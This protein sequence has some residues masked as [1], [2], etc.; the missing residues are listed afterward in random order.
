MKKYIIGVFILFIASSIFSQKPVF[1]EQKGDTI[2]FYLSCDGSLTEKDKATY[3]RI[4]F[5]DKEKLA[6]YG[7]II[8][9]YYPKGP[10]AL[11]ARYQN[12]LYDGNII[13][14]YKTGTIKETGIYKSNNRDS[15]WTFYFKNESVEKKIDY[16]HAQQRLIEYYNK[17]GKPVFL[18]GNGMYKGYSNKDYSS[19]EEYQIKGELKDGVMNGRWTINL[20]YSVSTE[21]FENGKFI[22]GHET[23]HNLI[24]EDASLINLSGFPYYEK[25]TLLDYSIACNK[26]GFYWPT[27]NKEIIE[28]S[29]LVEL[30]QKITEKINTNDFFYALLEFQLDNGIINSNSFK[31]ITNDKKKVDELKNFILS[32]DKWDTPK[33]KLSFTIYLPIFWENGLIYL[34]PKDIIKF[35]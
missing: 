4:G 1:F 2:I 9:Y 22:R 5:F 6:F 13:N 23:P 35:N 20:G 31:S 14:Y 11:K 10:I 18:D 30:E 15:I 3:K 25:I 27:Y 26:S 17:N 19:C 32:L 21:V 33:E 34:N 8:D 12:G 7:N 28:K 29:F 24:Y 16:G